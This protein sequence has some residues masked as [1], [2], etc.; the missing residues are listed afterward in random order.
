MKIREAEQKQLEEYN[1]K[2]ENETLKTFKDTPDE[3]TQVYVNKSFSDAVDI[4]WDPPEDNNSGI[5]KYKIYLSDR[6]IKNVGTADLQIKQKEPL[7]SSHVYSSFAST[8]DNC[9]ILKGLSENAIYYVLV[10]AVN[11]HGEG[12]R[13]EVPTM[14][15]TMPDSINTT[16]QLYVWGSN[17]F[18]EIGLTQE[19]V[20]ANKKFYHKTE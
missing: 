9:I 18:S 10:T 16:N 20:E 14:I 13:T 6:I 3:I 2:L 12:Y 17:S 8:K 15:R 5:T 1:E 7:S 19:H 4:S 11:K